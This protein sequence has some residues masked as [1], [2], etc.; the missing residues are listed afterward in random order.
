MTTWLGER[1]A[2]GMRLELAVSATVHRAR[3][4]HQS[5]TVV[6]TE[7]FGRALLLDDV[8]QT[9]ERDEHIYHEM[10]VHVPM[11][12]HG[13]ARRVLIVGGGDGGAL[14]EVLRHPVERATMVEIDAAVVAACRAHMPGLSAGAFDDPRTELHIADAVDHVARTAERYDVMIVDSTDPLPE[15]PGSVL[16]TEAFYR[17]CAR[18]L[19]DGGILVAQHGMP[20]VDADT[21]RRAHARLASAF[22]D[23]TCY[24]V[25]VPTY[26]GGAMALGWGACDAAQRAVPEDVLE[27]RYRAAGI[28]TRYW[29]PEVHRAAF[30]LPRRFP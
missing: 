25:P 2:D 17:D 4:P 21:V 13:A 3:S 7:R 18:L 16:F 26:C 23:A 28:T 29:T 8:I 15:G 12:A 5:I 6:E 27:T 19:S 1:P 20:F 10:L 22:A 9:T 14:R 11:L 30:A 24:L